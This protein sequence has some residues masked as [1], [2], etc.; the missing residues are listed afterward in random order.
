MSRDQDAHR[1]GFVE[2]F[3]ALDTQER[4]RRL[5]DA[6]MLDV[7]GTPVLLLTFD[8]TV[9]AFAGGVVRRPGGTVRVTSWAR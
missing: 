1:N 2:R 7:G 4:V 9:E 6:R 5:R 3:D 8:A